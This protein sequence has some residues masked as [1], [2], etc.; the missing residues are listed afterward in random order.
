M[1]T[2]TLCEFPIIQTPER[3]IVCVKMHHLISD[4]WTMV[5][6]AEQVKDFYVKIKNNIE[7]LPKKSYIDFI[8]NEE[9]YKNSNKFIKDE[10]FWKE[11]VS[12]LECKNYFNSPKNKSG[13]RAIKKLGKHLFSKISKYCSSNKISEYSFLLA[14]ISIYYSKI[15]NANKLVIGTPFLNRQKMNNE[16]E[17]LGMFISTLPISINIDPDIGILELCRQI[18]NTNF[19]CFKHC[20]YPY[21][22]I[23][24]QYQEIANENTNLYEI[25]FSFQINKLINDI[26]GDSGESAWLYNNEQQNPLTLSYINHFG[27]HTMVY[28]Y[29][30][31][32]FSSSYINKLHETLINI[33]NQLLNNITLVKDISI[34]SNEDLERLKS[35]N[36]TG[37][38][39]PSDDTLVSTLE[40][41]CEKY[42]SNV[43]IKER[44]YNINLSRI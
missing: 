36:N 43:A 1:F 16:L 30:T 34:L 18:S 44:K 5:Q 33:I 38:L 17:T 28:D 11:Y 8:N 29:L 3:T 42:K 32:C 10:A 22:E 40:K 26:D 37:N 21:Y 6:V 19:S 12:T 31:Q 41:T 15:L 14:V 7:I 13:K 39:K 23:Q 25:A 2:D 24:K 27:E 20:K 4:A 9:E 35:F